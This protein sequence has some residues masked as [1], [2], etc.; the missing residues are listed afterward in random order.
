VFRSGEKKELQNRGWILKLK[1]NV[2]CLE[3][4]ITLQSLRLG[5]IGELQA[6][7]R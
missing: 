3:L 1:E 5:A 6:V 7:A 4:N 2:A